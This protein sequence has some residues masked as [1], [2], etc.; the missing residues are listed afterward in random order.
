VVK[1][2]KVLYGGRQTVDVTSQVVVSP[3]TGCVTTQA[4]GFAMRTIRHLSHR[5]R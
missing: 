4:T 3:E 5:E 2:P 1:Y